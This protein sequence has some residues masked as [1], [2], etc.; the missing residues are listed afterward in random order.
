MLKVSLSV[1]V[2]PLTLGLALAGCGSSPEEECARLG[3]ER[4]TPQF[5]Y[6]MRRGGVEE[7]KTGGGAVSGPLRKRQRGF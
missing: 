3:W 6:C 2:L 5:D 1:A 7:D 4:G